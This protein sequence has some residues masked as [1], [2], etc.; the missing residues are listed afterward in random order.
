MKDKYDVTIGLEIHAELNTATKCFC[1]CKNDP[2]S[3][4]PNANCCPVCLAFP[5][6]LPMLNQNAVKKTIAAGL[7]MGCEINDL[8][9]FER[10]HYFYPDLSKAYQISQLVR[11]ICLGGGI[12]LKSGKF[13]RLNRIHLEEDAGK[14]LHNAINQTSLVDYNR[15]GVPLIELVSEPD[16]SS[17]EEAVEFL[18]EIRSRLI[19]SGVANCR[20]EQGG[21]RCDVNLSLKPKGSKT[22]GSRTEMKNINSFRMV[23]RAIEDETKRQAEILDKGERV[24][25]E[26]R[27]WDEAKGKSSSMRNKEEAQDYRYL[28]DPDIPHIKITKA[29]VEAIRKTMPVLAHQLREKFTTEYGLPEYDAGILTQTRDRANFYLDCVALLKEPKAI[30]NWIMTDV[31]RVMNERQRGH[32]ERNEAKRCSED[33]VDECI[34]VTAKQLVEI[35]SMV[36]SKKITKV[37]GE[38]LLDKVIQDPKSSP[39]D[40]AKKMGMLDE[41]TDKQ[42]IEILGALLKEK[43]NLADDYKANRQ[44][45]L[46]FIIGQVMKQTRGRAKSDIVEMLIEK[47][48]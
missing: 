37:V 47:T 22:L 5:G 21:F 35:I 12:K 48:Y 7:A 13:I 2:F 14:L 3:S 8:A 31:A 41:V 28:P 10:K 23:A 38:Q 40:I 16:L 30:S 9:I 26:T 20:M 33:M 11:P 45:V 18:E 27:K 29:D 34:P 17:A 44:K 25:S 43:P 1:G 19:F 24:I 36:L 4:E 39:A 32:I 46:P 15:G 6:A 42:I